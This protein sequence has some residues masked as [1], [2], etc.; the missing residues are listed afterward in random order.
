MHRSGRSRDRELPVASIILGQTA[1]PARSPSAASPH[2]FVTGRG[3]VYYPAAL[4]RNRRFEKLPVVR[5]HRTCGPLGRRANPALLGN[6]TGRHAASSRLHHSASLVQPA[7]IRYSESS[8]DIST[9][10]SGLTVRCRPEKVCTEA[11]PCGARRRTQQPWHGARGQ[12]SFPSVLP[13]YFRRVAQGPVIRTHGTG[14]F[15]HLLLW[16]PPAALPGFRSVVSP[17]R[18]RR[19][20]HPFGR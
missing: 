11:I 12:R 19:S 4:I 14:Y 18:V 5:R 1:A 16:L 20:S 10:P 2:C 9:V 13:R 8:A 7:R 15:H 6:L 3:D 17:T